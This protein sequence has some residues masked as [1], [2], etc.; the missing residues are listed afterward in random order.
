MEIELVTTL[1][2]T[3][4]FPI[5]LVLAMGWFIYKLQQESVDRE[6]KLYDIIRDYGTKI[7]S[8]T[9]TLERV[10]VK[11]DV[12]NTEVSELKRFEEEQK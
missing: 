12:L 11:L 3:L 4:G 7:E 2:S 1:I 8:I 6:N 9:T 5:V 10:V